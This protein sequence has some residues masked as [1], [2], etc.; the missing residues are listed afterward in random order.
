MPNPVALHDLPPVPKGSHFPIDLFATLLAHKL[1]YHRS[2]RDMVI[3]SHELVTVP[4]DAHSYAAEQRRASR[5]VHTSTLVVY[6]DTSAKG[7]SAMART[8]G[9]PLAYAT[10]RI[11]NGDIRV[12]GVRTPVDEEV[13]RPI[14]HDLEGAGIVMKEETSFGEGMGSSL[15]ANLRPPALNR[16]AYV[17]S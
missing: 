2:E 15:A 1:R 12:R 3:L 9:L 11:L 16:N 8:V 17:H 14:L 10:L 7:S 5:Q 13:Y 4:S 6:G